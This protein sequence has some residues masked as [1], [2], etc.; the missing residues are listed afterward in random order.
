M[1][2]RIQLRRGTAAQW[3]AANPVLAQG[4]PGIETD[5]GKQKFGNGVAT[6]AALAYASVGPQGAP[7]AAGVADDA[8]IAA[9]VAAPASAT[10][11]AL[12]ATYV[13]TNAPST[14]TAPLYQ[15]GLNGEDSIV[16]K[17]LGDGHTAV[18]QLLH[19]DTSGFIDH[20]VSGPQMS[21]ADGPGGLAGYGVGTPGIVGVVV[22][23]SAE[24]TGQQN[25]CFAGVGPN[26]VAHQVSTL[27]QAFALKI[28][29]S[30]PGTT[31]AGNALTITAENATAP[32]DQILAEFKTVALAGS[33][34]G[35]TIF[36]VYASTGMFEFTSPQA[37]F[38]GGELL[39]SDFDSAHNGHKNQ[40]NI[41]GSSVAWRTETG[42]ASLLWSHRINT[43]GTEVQF[44][45]AGA[46]NKGAETWATNLRMNSV[47][48]GFYG[49][50]PIA[51]PALLPLDAT[52]LA[53]AINLLNYIKN[54]VIKPLG[55][56]S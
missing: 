11:T 40:V 34:Q 5:T 52:D 54:G 41:K 45:S 44:Q 20:L 14:I 10:R 38:N 48:L 31:K 32:A 15:R 46:A 56:A 4:E 30:A 9:Q 7:G 18:R 36:R 24:A 21:S 23:V 55:L 51:K 1:A 33:T 42:S 50:A 39:V 27:G 3:S 8:S 47:G 37:H 12:N 13:K 43:S 26:G 25:I 2:N 29:Q 6:W 17:P 53:T 28:N 35:A 19:N 16:I 22:D 49:S